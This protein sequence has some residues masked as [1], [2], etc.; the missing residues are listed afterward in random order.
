MT[1]PA[2]TLEARSAL[3]RMAGVWRTLRREPVLGAVGAAGLLATGLCVVAIAGRGSSVTP[4]GDLAEAAKFTVGVAIFTWTMAWLLPL[5]GWSTPATRRWRASY[6]IFAVYGVILEPTQ[7][8]RGLD[9]RFSDDGGTIDS[10]AGSVFGVTALVLLVSFVILGLRFFQP[11][12]LADR[13]L[14]RLGIRYG[15]LAV[16]VS[17]AVGAMMSVRQGRELGDDGDLMVAH[18]LGVHGIQTIPLVTLVLI[19]TRSIGRIT[20]VAHAA[21]LGWLAAA[22]AAAIQALLGRPAVEAS[23][24]PAVMIAGLVL[25]AIAAGYPL[26]ARRQGE[27]P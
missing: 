26:L 13:P 12:V 19:E 11:G 21:G 27:G 15:T 3:T 20:A 18:M 23:A 16:F 22:L 2:L 14:L 17:F 4:E 24:L 1:T 10:I 8:F 5:T 25:W 6:C 7:A 9:P